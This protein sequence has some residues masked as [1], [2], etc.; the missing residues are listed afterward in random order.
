[1]GDQTML[2][3][4]ILDRGEDSL[5]LERLYRSDPAKFAG[6]LEHALQLN[7]EA[8]ILK[9]WQARFEYT[10]PAKAIS[11]AVT[12]R[13]IWYPVLLCLLATLFVRIPALFEVNE[14]WFYTRF[15]PLIVFSA[16]IF[17][18]SH[19][20][21]HRKSV[22]V[23][24]IAGVMTTGLAMALLPAD[25]QSSSFFMSIIHAP[26]LL[27]A[28]LG[29]AFTSNTWRSAKPRLDYLR[30][31]GEVFIFTTMILL[32]GIVLTGLTIALFGLIQLDIEQWYLRNVVLAGLVSAPILAT[33]LYNEILG[34]NSRFASTIANIF[35]PLF[36]ITVVIYLLTMAIQQ[37]SPFSDRDFLILF[38][39]LLILV[40]GMT[41]FSVCGRNHDQPSRL[42]DSI[43]LALV[44]VTL[45]VNL[46]AL[47]AILY[48]FSEWGLS[49][50]RVVVLGA[51]VLIFGH[52]I[53]ILKAYSDVF[54][55]K[56]RAEKL[57]K[58]T[59]AFL[60]IYGAWAAVVMIALPIVF[61]FA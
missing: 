58:A 53:Q 34:R 30:Y 6:H 33:F 14:L 37:K 17:Y 27:L 25:Y 22:I 21:S 49:P 57:I 40:L 32:G 47:A 43:N 4:P 31:N 48:R 9:F 28:L 46:I 8:P 2:V 38:N 18:F 20:T 36:L 13:Q 24:M 56:I 52:L 29:L 16:L 42:V 23:F 5:G 19:Q 26:L 3:N 44:C 51:N 61:R 41:V 59:V 15:A 55:G 10:K 11:T 45:M 7:P 39:G 54:R 60:P 1:M 35:T 12:G 50:N